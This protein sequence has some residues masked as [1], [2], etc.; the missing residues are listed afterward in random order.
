MKVRGKIVPYELSV[1][2]EKLRTSCCFGLT[3]S[4]ELK[5]GLP[6]TPEAPHSQFVTNRAFFGRY[7][8]AFIGV[9]GTLGSP[10]THTLFRTFFPVN[11]IVVFPPS[12]PTRFVREQDYLFLTH[13]EHLQGIARLVRD[14]VGRGRV[15]LVVS[16][17]V[18]ASTAIEAALG[19]NVPVIPYRTLS[20]CV[21]K[22]TQPCVILATNKGGRGT[23]FASQ[24]RYSK[25]VDFEC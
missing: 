23:A 4:L 15:V 16:E 10:A 6:M 2:D 14:T 19:G 3:Q 1:G 20:D 18:S 7:V 5:L 13:D 22:V 12:L 25:T 24:Q 17:T 11:S 8:A 21:I 9:S